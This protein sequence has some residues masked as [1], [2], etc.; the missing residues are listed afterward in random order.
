MRSFL[1]G[2]AAGCVLGL[3]ILAVVRVEHARPLFSMSRQAYT[4]EVI[5]SDGTTEHLDVNADGRACARL[6]TSQQLSEACRLALN[7]DP[8]VI[9]AAALGQLNH[10]DTPA[11]LALILRARMSNDSAICEKG[12]L[13]GLRLARCHEAVVGGSPTFSDSGVT[14]R[15]P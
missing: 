9:A 11:L 8:N 10:V 15:I 5:H 3:A 6:G 7:I 2:L 12:G 1:K 13:E 14:I 4:I